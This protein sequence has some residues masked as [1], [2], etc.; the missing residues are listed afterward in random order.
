MSES[1]IDLSGARPGVQAGARPK[2]GS[3]RTTG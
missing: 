2:A 1:E 3:T